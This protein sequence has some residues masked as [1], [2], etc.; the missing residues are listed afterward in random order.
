MEELEA[1]AM[2]ARSLRLQL[3]DL[4]EQVLLGEV[5][6]GPAEVAGMLLAGALSGLDTEVYILTD[7]KQREK[8]VVR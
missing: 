2:E 3:Q 5:D 4:A 8:G 7:K 6:Q 1:L